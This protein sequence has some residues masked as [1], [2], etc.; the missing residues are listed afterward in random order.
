[1]DR[2]RRARGLE[3][4]VGWALAACLCLSLLGGCDKLA[5][6]AIFTPTLTASP[7]AS[8]VPSSTQTPSETPAPS[9]T[10][11]PSATS[12]PSSTSSSTP[13]V[14]LTPS[15]TSTTTLGPSP[16]SSL[17]PSRTLTPSD[18][19]V[20]SL[21]RTPNRTP[22]PSFTPTIT[23]TPTPP[24]PQVAIAIPGLLSR[25][26]SPIQAEIYAV[27]DDDGMVRVELIGE[28]GRLIARQVL[29]MSAYK[30]RS[31]ALYPKIPF[32]INSAAET[33]RL[34]VLTSD[35]FG[36]V[37]ALESV[38]LILLKVG[39]NE[40]FDPLITMEPFIIR[41]PEQG[42]TVSGDKLVIQGLIRPLNDSP[43]I[44]EAIGEDSAVLLTKQFN[45]AAPSGPLSHT[46]FQLEIS[47]KVSSPTPIRLIF[48]QAGS[49][50]PGTL[51]LTSLTLILAP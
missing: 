2:R 42:D 38:D 6:S 7:T 28:D 48:R 20:P 25:V 15:Q 19:L 29:D 22:T 41:S 9:A 5:V 34:Q 23:L 3:W 39:R 45:V 47:Y 46:P 51:A 14:T 32:E 31:I 1:M 18:T 35:R 10:D 24:P 13:T 33:A 16:T 40:I 8:L 49:R 44:V 50:I 4:Q 36:R 17:T 12:E 27:P 37:V 30:H 43:V 26:V 11:V 21:T